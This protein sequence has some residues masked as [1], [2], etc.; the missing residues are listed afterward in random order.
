MINYFANGSK[1]YSKER[2]ESHS[3]EKG[4][5]LDIWRELR[6]FGVSGF[7]KM[8]SKQDKAHKAQFELLVKQAN[9]GGD[10]L[11]PF[12]ET[13]NATKASFAAIESLKAGAWV[14]V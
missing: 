3:H 8:K 7:K 11:V 10:P 1:S 12:K 4:F 14:D 2:I 5:V 13:V 6:A 9:D